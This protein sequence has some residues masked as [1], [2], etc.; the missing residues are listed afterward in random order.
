VQSAIFLVAAALMIRS[1]DF[2]TTPDPV[3]SAA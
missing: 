3:L 2:V 1:Q